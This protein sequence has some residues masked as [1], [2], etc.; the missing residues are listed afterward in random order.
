MINAALQ[1]SSPRIERGRL[2][3][4][5]TGGPISGHRGYIPAD[6]QNMR[7]IYTDVLLF[8]YF[9]PVHFQDHTHTFVF[10]LLANSL[11]ITAPQYDR[12]QSEDMHHLL[13]PR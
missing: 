6:I 11:L 12:L 2:E 7:C 1:M 13:P 10:D 8:F 4:G 5:G 3:T 9:S